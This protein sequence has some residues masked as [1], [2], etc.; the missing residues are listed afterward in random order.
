MGLRDVFSLTARVAAGLPTPSIQRFPVVSPFA[1]AGSLAPIVASDVLGMGAVPVATRVEAMRVPAIVKGR[2]LIAG[3]LSRY[4]LVKF[5][6]ADRIPSD[7]WMYRTSTAQ[8]PEMRLLWTLDDLIFHGC[9]L[10]ALQRG[11]KGQVLDAVRVLPDE[12]AVDED[13]RIT[14]RGERVLEDEVCLFEGPQDGLLT[15]AA[16]DIYASRAMARAWTQRVKSPVPLLELHLTDDALQL[17]DVEVVEMRDQ[18]ERARSVSGTAVTPASVDVK[19]HGT[20]P[21]DLFVQGRNA[22]RLDWANY[23]NL[24]GALL[25]GSTA[26]ASLTYSTKE[27]SRAELVDYSLSYW[28]T[29]ITARLSQDDMVPAGQR[30]DLDLSWLSTPMPVGVGPTKED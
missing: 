25:D 9:S 17:D 22:A 24:P 21:T 11:A 19:E 3:T 18:W 7:A 4:P 2:A 27:G 16:E 8:A 10:W 6:G 28:A 13:N 14:V 12:W 30:V 1:S 26:T 23:L 5:R 29:A 20:A 15:I